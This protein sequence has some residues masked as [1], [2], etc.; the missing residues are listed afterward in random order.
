[1]AP[2]ADFELT[3]PRGKL[4]PE[5]VTEVVLTARAAVARTMEGRLHVWEL[6]SRRWVGAVDGLATTSRGLRER[7]HERL[8]ASADGS[9]AAVWLDGGKGRPELALVDVRTARVAARL[10]DPGCAAHTFAMHPSKPELAVGSDGVVCIW[11]TTTSRL[12]RRMRPQIFPP[13]AGVA[14]GMTAEAR[15]AIDALPF[16]LLRYQGKVPRVAVDVV[17]VIGWT[18]FED[19][20]SKSLSEPDPRGL[21]PDGRYAADCASTAQGG[22]C[23]GR[24]SIVEV[25]TGRVVRRFGEHERDAALRWTEAGLTRIGE[26]GTTSRWGP[27]GFVA[28]L[29]PP[30]ELE[31]AT[32]V[33]S[34]SRTLLVHPSPLRGCAPRS[35]P[36][37][38][39]RSRSRR[40]PAPSSCR[41]RGPSRCSRTACG[42]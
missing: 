3:P 17:Y 37:G 39:P 6:P 33:S 25:A 13:A 28:T 11:D 38:R 35:L 1:M 15:K 24:G 20:V 19:D 2:L 29:R 18:R 9:V 12:V 22:P 36:P 32:V 8:E 41:R 21:S 42:R 5:H 7:E 40:H 16:E 34:A 23:R 30:P 10:R 26:Q 14:Q 27:D 31:P 4:G